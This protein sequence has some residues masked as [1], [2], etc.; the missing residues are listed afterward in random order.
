MK[1]VNLLSVPYTSQIGAGANE[2]GADCGAASASMLIKAYLNKTVSVDEL[3]N[4]V[5]KEINGYLSINQVQNIL[6]YYG[7]ATEWRSDMTKYNLI[8]VLVEGKP[9]IVLFN[10]A[11]FRQKYG[12]TSDMYF[13][14]A[15]F[16]VMIGL[17][18]KYFYLNDPDWLDQN[19]YA[20]LIKH[21]DWMYAWKAAANDENPICG[22][23]IP[24]VS[25]GG[26]VIDPTNDGAEVIYQIKVSPKIGLFVRSSPKK[27]VSNYTGKTV[28]YNE[29]VDIY[30]ESKDGNNLWG[31]INSNCTEWIAL[32]YN[33]EVLA[34]KV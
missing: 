18:T 15:H 26:I 3:Y 8:N 5:S 24:T 23:I 12:K 17:D 25:L 27:T 7:I 2:H 28:S 32:L 31:A 34:E 11:A 16:S 9:C 1:E 21:D 13:N 14:G 22:A 10:Y 6:S 19:G 4:L 20:L 29:I 33:N 30:K